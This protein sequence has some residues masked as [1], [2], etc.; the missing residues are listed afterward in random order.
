[1]IPFLDCSENKIHEIAAGLN[2][3]QYGQLL[4]PL[5]GYRL[6][7][8]V[9]FGVDNG[10]YTRQDMP[11]FIAT[12]EKARPHKARCKF[13]VMPDVPGSAIRTAELFAEFS[14]QFSD[15][16]LALAIQDGIESIEIPWG[17]LSAVFVA[18]TTD[19]RYKD[20]AKHVIAAAKWRGLWV[21]VGRVSNPEQWEK[22]RKM[23]ADSG[24]SS[25]LV[26]PFPGRIDKMKKYFKD[27]YDEKNSGDDN[28]F[29][30]LNSYG[31][32]IDGE[33]IRGLFDL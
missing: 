29:G 19:W 12:V 4:T 32:A 23:G 26:I 24:D 25:A 5:T 7:E 33:R 22:Y 30:M 27:I 13:V 6:A 16:P 18:G 17:K 11:R 3:P 14:Q 20:Y 28:D 21:H 2:C 15:M 31:T 8:N 1:M 10:G 9:S